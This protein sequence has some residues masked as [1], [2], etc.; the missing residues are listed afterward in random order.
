MVGSKCRDFKSREVSN[1]NAPSVLMLKVRVLHKH[2][3]DCAGASKSQNRAS[4]LKDQE[5]TVA[6]ILPAKSILR[7]HSFQYKK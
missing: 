1:V 3:P 2:L 4:I 5:I 7:T 6:K